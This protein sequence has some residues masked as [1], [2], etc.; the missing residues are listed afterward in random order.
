V[1]SVSRRRLREHLAEKAAGIAVESL[2]LHLL[3]RGAIVG[4]GRDGNTVQQHRELQAAD[5]GR[6]LHHILA[7]RVVAPGGCCQ[8]RFVM[9]ALSKHHPSA[10]WPWHSRV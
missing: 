2:H 10:A 7:D 8:Q 6:L 3:D 1:P 5:A 4:T 9:V